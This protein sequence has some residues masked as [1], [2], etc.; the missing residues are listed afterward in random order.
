MA[1]Q[2]ASALSLVFVAAVVSGHEHIYNECQVGQD[3][4]PDGSCTI[5]IGDPAAVAVSVQDSVNDCDSACNDE[6]NCEFFTYNIITKVCTLK[7]TSGAAYGDLDAEENVDVIS[8][9]QGCTDRDSRNGEWGMWE[10]WTLCLARARF[11]YCEGPAPLG[12]G[13]D[14][15]SD[16]ATAIV[17]ECMRVDCEKPELYT[18]PS[19]NLHT[20]LEGTHGSY[21]CDITCQTLVHV[22][23]ASTITFTFNR[24]DLEDSPNCANDYMELYDGPSIESNRIGIFC[25][26]TLPGPV[27]STGN[28]MLMVFVADNSTQLMGF[29]IDYTSA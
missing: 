19:G 10:P 21:P 18:D 20:P 24:F 11:R 27:T 7:A 23:A 13:A 6:A 15:P 16:D 14:C 9:W 29:D 22:A 26:S 3:V 28:S 25:G 8:G 5:S 2:F 4:C 17:T 12:S 1:W